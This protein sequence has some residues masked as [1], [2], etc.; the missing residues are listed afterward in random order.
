M[1]QADEIPFG[2]YCPLAVRESFDELVEMV[3][4]EFRFHREEAFICIA[5]L[6]MGSSSNGLSWES[7]DRGCDDLDRLGSILFKEKAIP[8]TIHLTGRSGIRILGV[9]KRPYP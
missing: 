3:E 6:K 1:P 9:G 7:L 5:G 2:I 4:R 8:I